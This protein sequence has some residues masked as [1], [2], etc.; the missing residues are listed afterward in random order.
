MSTST[1][2]RPGSL[3][4][5]YAGMQMEGP[6]A[7]WYAR[8]TRVRHDRLQT[9]QSI[10]AQVAPGGAILEVAPGPGYLS[11]ELAKLGDFRLTGLDISRS[12]VRIASENARQA[13]VAI[14]FRHGDVGQMPFASD[15]FDLIVCQAAF[16]NFP[17]PVAALDEMYRVLKPGGRVSILDLRKE[18]PLDAVRAEVRS[19]Q[20]SA[21]NAW[22]TGL[23]FRFALIRAAY[24]RQKLEAVVAQSRFRH[25]EIVAQGIGF[26]LRLSK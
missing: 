14:D 6:L 21:L 18:A 11:I 22:M 17:N 23:V 3:K 12:L 9:A 7:T 1:L 24:P 5:P 15:S 10:A 19:M 2:F 16:K 4:K 26:D 20:L 25:G 8:S 13:G